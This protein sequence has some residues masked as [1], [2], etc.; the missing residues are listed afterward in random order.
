MVR[1]VGLTWDQEAEDHIARHSVDPDEV[2]EA[3][4]NVR[5]A[6]R[7]NSYLLVLGQAESGRYLAVVLDYE[8]DGFW[9][10]VTARD[11]TSRERRLLNRRA[12]GRGNR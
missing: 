12:R 5:Y 6:K 9:Y 8:G 3:V 4:Q 2:E 1:I 10:P 7:S 11:A